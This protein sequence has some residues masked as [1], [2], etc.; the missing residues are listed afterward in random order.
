MIAQQT[1]GKWHLI[2]LVQLL[3]TKQ[4]IEIGEKAWAKLNLPQRLIPLK[5]GVFLPVNHRSMPLGYNETGKLLVE[6]ELFQILAVKPDEIYRSAL[7]SELRLYT[8][9]CPWDG[10]QHFREYRYRLNELM[11]RPGHGVNVFG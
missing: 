11:K 6:L 10:V 7:D 4:D 9:V 2:S 1:F 3:N 8:T 5:T